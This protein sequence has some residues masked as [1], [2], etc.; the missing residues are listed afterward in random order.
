MDHPHTRIFA[1]NLQDVIDAQ[2]D[3]AREQRGRNTSGEES[4]SCL[5]PLDSP[6]TEPHERGFGC[7]PSYE[8]GA[9][10]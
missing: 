4:T 5:S 2:A 10:A 1:E 6:E 7:T 8:A 9:D 3:A